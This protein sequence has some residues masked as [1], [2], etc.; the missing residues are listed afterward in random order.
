MWD[1]MIRFF[2]FALSNVSTS[3]QHGLNTWP[4][5]PA[6]P[7]PNDQNQLQKNLI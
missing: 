1:E 3:K 7:S 6:L 2:R 4:L 5:D